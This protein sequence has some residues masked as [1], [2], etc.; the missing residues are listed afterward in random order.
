MR[1]KLSVWSHDYIPK[2]GGSPV[3]AVEEREEYPENLQ[4]KETELFA[5]YRSPWDAPDAGDRLDA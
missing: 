4:H 3:K 2:G 1:G 5:A